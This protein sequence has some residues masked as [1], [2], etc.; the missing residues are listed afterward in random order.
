MKYYAFGK[1]VKNNILYTVSYEVEAN[2]E[3]QARAILSQGGGVLR[4]R[5]VEEELGLDTW[6]FDR[7]EDNAEV[8]LP[9]QPPIQPIIAQPARPA[10]APNDDDVE[11]VQF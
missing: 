6:V 2:S 10:P 11:D 7:I 4:W 1:E 5:D 8:A 3:L 9:I